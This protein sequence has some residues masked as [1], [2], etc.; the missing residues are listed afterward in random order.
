M[1]S[2][3]ERAAEALLERL[4]ID[5]EGPHPA[6]TPFAEGFGGLEI[7]LPPVSGRFPFQ[8]V[9]E[10]LA[11]TIADLGDQRHVIRQVRLRRP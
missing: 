8:A 3:D 5:A 11:E 4:R 2:G 6:E 7:P 10:F 1:A 9:G